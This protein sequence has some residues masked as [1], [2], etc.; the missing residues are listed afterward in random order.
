MVDFIMYHYVRDLKASRYP[1]IKGL[2]Y[3]EFIEQISHLNKYYNIISIEDFYHG[4]YNKN[5]KNCVLT[6]DDGYSDHY[7][8]VFETLQN[9][10]VKG[11]FFVFFDVVE[12]NKVL[13]VNK[14]QLILASQDEK[15]VWER[16]KH[17]YKKLFTEQ[18]PISTHID[19][20]DPSSRFRSKQ[21]EKKNLGHYN[22][23]INN[24]QRFDSNLIVIIKKL[25]QTE[26]DLKTR[27][28]L[29]NE[30]LHD[31]VELSEA[32]ISTELYLNKSQ[33]EEMIN[34]GMNFGSHGKSHLWFDS[35]TYKQQEKE[36]TESISFLNSLYKE[37]YFLSM[38]YPYGSFDQNTLKLMKKYDFKIAL[39][40]LPG[41][42]N[43]ELDKLHLIP[44]MDTND[45]YPKSF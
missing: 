15:V 30:L 13:D 44:R 22:Y 35:L 36:I 12:K 21:L 31:F 10:K 18:I 17:H 11:S 42:Y 19:K 26:L 14:I 23:N 9:F 3:K 24:S 40:D 5:K 28:I 20:I 43:P 6:F 39:T 41:V 2:D 8:Y 32:E 16:L 45:Y 34:C 7:D 29:C 25:L 27:T 1:K 37:D 38:S 4:D 33:I